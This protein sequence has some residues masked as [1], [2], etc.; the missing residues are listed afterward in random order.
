[1]PICFF[2]AFSYIQHKNLLPPSDVFI[3]GKFIYAV[4]Q[5][6]NLDNLQSYLMKKGKLT[7]EELLTISR[8]I[9]NGYELIK[10][11]GLIHGNIK[12]TNILI[13]ENDNL[14]I[15]LTDFMFRI[16]EKKDLS[17]DK[18]IAPEIASKEKNPNTISDVYSIGSIIKL[19]LERTKTSNDTCAKLIKDCL[20]N[21]PT[22]RIQFDVLSLHPFF[23]S[24]YPTYKLF[25]GKLFF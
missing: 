11:K 1:M 19:L 12:P 22:K 25:Y 4:Y 2:F 14:T 13:D 16:N 18:F 8:Q 6:S 7:Q 5:Y 9:I 17:N 15:K 20:Q 21:D 23:T 3:K 24:I 10:N